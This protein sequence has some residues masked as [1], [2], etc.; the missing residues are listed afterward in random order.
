MA[1]NGK[2][3]GGRIG[4]VTGRSQTHNPRT[5]QWVKR[6]TQTGQ[7]M[8]VKKDGEPFKGVRKEDSNDRM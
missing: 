4:A 3:G 6:D 1:K 7:F 5:G 2:L 8:D